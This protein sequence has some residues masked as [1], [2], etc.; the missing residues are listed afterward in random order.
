MADVTSS[1]VSLSWPNTALNSATYCGIERSMSTARSCVNAIS[2]GLAIGPPACSFRSFARP[3]QN[4]ARFRRELSTVGE[5]IGP[6]CQR[7]P[8]DEV[9]LSEPPMLR[10]WHE[11]HEMKP[12][13]ERRGSKNSFLPRSTLAASVTF[14]ATIGEIGSAA[15]A[16]P[17]ASSSAAAI[18]PNGLAREGIGM[19]FIIAPGWKNTPGVD[20][21]TV[22]SA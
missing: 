14:T 2:P 18:A 4:C 19:V 17:A 22:S 20:F 3:S 9:I 21:R 13:R 8:I 10:L 16:A 1:I 6:F 11:L 15:Q 7:S 5:L 12:E